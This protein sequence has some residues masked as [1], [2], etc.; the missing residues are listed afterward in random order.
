[1]LFFSYSS[2]YT[3][4][5]IENTSS[6]QQELLIAAFEIEEAYTQ[7]KIQVQEWKNILLRGKNP[8]DFQ[9]YLASFN[10]QTD[11]VQQH[12]AKAKFA[13]YTTDID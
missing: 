3:V 10:H 4:Q 7:F 5:R 12:L 8:T 6:Q 1:M 2:L 13:F 11:E 9:Y